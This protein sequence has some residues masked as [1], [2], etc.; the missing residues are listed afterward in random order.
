[1]AQD[2]DADDDE[3]TIAHT[4]GGADY[5]ANGVTAAPV[6]VTVDDD[7]TAAPGL[8]L[9]LTVEH[10]DADGSGDVT[11]GDV[12]KYT[13]RATNSGNVELAE[14]KVSDLRV[15]PAG[16]ECATLAV[17]AVCELTGALYGDAGGRGRGRGEQHGAVQVRTG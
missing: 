3:A 16:Q 14:V 6:A 13:A 7:E 8:A 5:E 1:M 10:E 17:G 4:V 9:T 2:D 12:L 15:D 11:L